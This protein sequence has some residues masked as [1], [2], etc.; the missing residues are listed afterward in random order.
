MKLREIIELVDEGYTLED[1]EYKNRVYST[2]YFLTSLIF[3][4]I[5]IYISYQNFD[6]V[7][8]ALMLLIIGAILI[9]RQKHLYRRTRSYFDKIF[10]RIVEY[11]VV[12]IVISSVISLYVH[13]RIFMVFI[14][15][16]F[17][18]LLAIDGILFKS[19][20][21]KI[22]GALTIFSSV[23]I[24]IFAEYQFLIF[25]II[26]LFIAICFLISKEWN[27]EHLQLYS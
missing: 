2:T 20:K 11:G 8:I 6:I 16:I 3:I 12:T 26:Q 17:G 10:E 25:G 1:R 23:L 14:A 9:I 19:R 21:R 24:F 15:Q 13:P 5:Q 18:L 4:L 22:L 27:Y 7:F